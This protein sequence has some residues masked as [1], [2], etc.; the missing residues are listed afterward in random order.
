MTALGFLCSSYLIFH[1]YKT[2]NYKLFRHIRNTMCSYVTTHLHWNNDI[3]AL[4]QSTL[5]HLL[6]TPTSC[7]SDTLSQYVRKVTWQ[8]VKPVYK[9]TCWIAHNGHA[10]CICM[11]SYN[12]NRLIQ[13]GLRAD[14][15]TDYS[16]TRRRNP[17]R[18]VVLLS[19]YVNTSPGIYIDKSGFKQQSLNPH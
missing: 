3:N 4:T 5:N 11:S 6:P 9:C 18:K 14:L 16:L 19:G 15:F 1:M 7:R 13:V 2:W 17:H 8:A 10:Q 12:A